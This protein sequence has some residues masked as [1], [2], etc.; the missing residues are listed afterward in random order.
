MIQQGVSFFKRLGIVKTDISLTFVILTYNHSGFVLEHLESIAHL[1]KK[2]DQINDLIV[3]DDA[4][5]DSTVGGISDW[6]IENRKLFREVTT[7]FAND[8]VG[9]CKSFLRATENIKTKNTSRLL[10]ALTCF[11]TKTFFPSFVAGV[12]PILLDLSR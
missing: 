4:S 2:Y 10:V 7:F 8:N 3:S 1:V 9:T 6:L 12:M 11:P 5:A